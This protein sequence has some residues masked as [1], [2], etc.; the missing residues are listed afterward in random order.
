MVGVVVLALTAAL[1]LATGLSPLVVLLW[2]V[3]LLVVRSSGAPHT[4]RHP[5]RG[6]LRVGTC[7]LGLG[8]VVGFF[9]PVTLTRHDLAA[10]VALAT[11]VGAAVGAVP[12]LARRTLGETATGAVLVGSAAQV[13]RVV[14]ELARDGGERFAVTGIC[15][16]DAVDDPAP[17]VAATT[18]DFPGAQVTHGLERVGPAVS[19]LG[20]DAVVALAGPALAA[21]DLRRLGWQIEKLGA[22]LFVDFGLVDTAPVRT[23]VTRAGSARL[24]KVRASAPAP[25]R[26][27]VKELWERCFAALAL[28]LL[29]PLLALLALAVRADGGGHAI[30]RQVRVGR[31]GREF[32]LLKLRTMHAD[33]EERLADMT[34]LNEA[35]EVL[36]KMR[37]DPRITRVGRV[38]RRCSLDELPQLWNVVRGDMALVGPRPALP[39]EVAVYPADAHRRLAVKPGLTG[40]WQVSGRSDLSWEESQRIDLR[41]VDNWSLALDLGIVLRT[42]RAVVSQQGAY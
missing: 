11:V 24:V 13:G 31:D 35:D 14:H 8:A 5:V 21:D 7:A 28:L 25:L 29:A 22:T 6:A 36:F 3:A 1:V 39:S 19:L 4:G 23:R 16:T 27:V 30:F 17:L 26:R 37:H 33:A 34:D 2:S 32:V 40:L 9:L 41:Y 10:G 38:L 20:A 18:A 42:V 15:L 12:R